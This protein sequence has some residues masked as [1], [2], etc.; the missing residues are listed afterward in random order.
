M[1]FVVPLLIKSSII[2]LVKIQPTLRNSTTRRADA[3]V[4]PPRIDIPI[5]MAIT[6]TR[7]RSF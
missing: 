1:S 4:R 3:I 7:A 2:C 6:T 5:N